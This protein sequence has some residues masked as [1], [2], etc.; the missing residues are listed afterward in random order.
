MEVCEIQNSSNAMMMSLI[1]SLSTPPSKLFEAVH[2]VIVKGWCLYSAVGSKEFKKRHSV[3]ADLPVGHS[4][5]ITLSTQP[6]Q[7]SFRQEHL[8]S[9]AHDRSDRSFSPFKQQRPSR[10]K[11]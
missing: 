5:T 8:S 11:Y 4:D 9:N 3:I 7:L 6:S 10:C 2:S 1:S